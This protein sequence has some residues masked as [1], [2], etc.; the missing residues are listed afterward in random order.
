MNQFP[1]F[2][3]LS[4]LLRTLDSLYRSASLTQYEQAR[5][6]AEAQIKTALPGFTIAYA[7]EVA[8]VGAGAETYHHGG[9]LHVLVPLPSLS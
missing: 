5:E 7:L 9:A 6:E 8:T 2:S 1:S 3:N 4:H